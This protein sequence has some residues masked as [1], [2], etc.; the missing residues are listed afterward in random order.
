MTE[1]ENIQENMQEVF[2]YQCV[3]TMLML[4]NLGVGGGVGLFFVAVAPDF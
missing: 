2:L 4:Q 3:C 1:R